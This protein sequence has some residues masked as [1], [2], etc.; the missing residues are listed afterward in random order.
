[1]KRQFAVIGLGRFGST[2]AKTLGQLGETVIAIDEDE[3]KV[4]AIKDFVA[5]AKQANATDPLSLREA[6]VANCDTA[7]IATGNSSAIIITL[8]LAEMGVKKIIAKADDEIHGMALQKVGATKVVFPEQDSGIRLANQ[9]V[10]SEILEYIEISKEYS[11]QELAVPRGLIGKTL[12]QLD[13]RKKYNVSII[14]IK[15]KDE[16]IVVPSRTD[17]LKQGDILF[18]IGRHANIKKFI[19]DFANK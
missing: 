12:M 7:I 14:A 2:V 11:V 17:E 3:A 9:L 4:N 5:Y 6:G 19:N 8:V 18:L 13:F 1:M 16:I 15:R 10:S